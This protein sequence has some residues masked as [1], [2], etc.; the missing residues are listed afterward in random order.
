V[1]RRRHHPEKLHPLHLLTGVPLHLAML[2]TTEQQLD[3][4]LPQMLKLMPPI[5]EM[6]SSCL[7]VPFL[8]VTFL[9]AAYGYDVN[10]PQFKEWQ[11]SQQQQY[12]QYYASQGYDPSAYPS[13]G[14]PQPNDPA[15]PPP[16]P[17]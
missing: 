17:P 13:T 12:A 6:R 16:P 14:V 2:L 9:R 11:A 3:L 10:A 7:D 1:L 4:Q 5:G 8:T 15:P